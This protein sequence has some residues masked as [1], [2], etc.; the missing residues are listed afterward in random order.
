MAFPAVVPGFTVTVFP[1]KLAVAI[2][3]FE[4][5]MLTFVVFSFIVKDVLFGYVKVPLYEESVNFPSAL[6]TFIVSVVICSC[7]LLYLLLPLL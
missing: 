3:V 4:D 1:F 7:S 6:F 5:V 2:L